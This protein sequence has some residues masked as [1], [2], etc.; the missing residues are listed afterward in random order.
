MLKLS[1]PIDQIARISPPYK[2]RLGRLKIQTL[3]DLLYHI[4]S[5]YHDFS[6]VVPIEKLE[7]GEIATVQGTV[8][9]I[10]NTRTWKKRMVLTEAIVEDD[11]GTV[12]AIWFNQPY[13]VRN[14]GKG[15]RISL[16]GKLE[17]AYENTFLSNPAY[18]II[19]GQVT[20]NE[21]REGLTHT[22]GLIAVYPETAGVSSRWLRYIIKTLL[23]KIEL[24]DFLPPEIK[25]AHDLRG[26]AAALE[27][28]H[29]P[30]VREDHKKA[31][32][33]LS[34]EELFLLSLYVLRERM[35]IKRERARVIPL[36]IPL[37][38]RFVRSLPF[39]LTNA[40]RLAL[41]EILRDTA[42]PEPMNR[43]LE[44]DVGS[45]KTIV[46]TAAALH[47]AAA[48]YQSAFMA[49][50]EI[51]A[52]QHFNEISKTLAKENVT[53]GLL[54][55]GSAKIAFGGVATTKQKRKD[56][57]EGVASGE[58]DILIGTHALIEDRV[59][60]K[61][62]AS[63]VVDEQHRFGIRQRMALARGNPQNQRRTS[64]KL[65]RNSAS[66]LQESAQQMRI[67]HLLSMTATPIPRTLALTIY[68]DL[69]ISL[70]NEMP[71]GRQKI[72]TR[73]VPPAKRSDAYQFIAKEI[74]KGRQIFIICPLIDESEKLEDVAAA[75]KEHERL[76]RNVFSRFRLELLHGKIK[77]KEKERIMRAFKEGKTDVLVSTSVV[78]VGIDIPNA[79]VMLIEGADRFGLAQLHQFRGRVGRGMHQS[80]CLL[81]T[82]STSKS[83]HARLRALVEA[84][85]GFELAEHDLKIRGPGEFYGTRQSGL[86]DIAMKSLGDITLVKQTREAAANLLKKDPDLAS[87]PLL[88][89]KL[90]DFRKTIHLE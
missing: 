38:K 80:Y 58:I 29:F 40:Q 21:Q 8:A 30:K 51:L 55:G 49:P 44:G 54:T 18:E 14:I 43:L 56:V 63:V 84:K 65:L 48:G 62:L 72:I 71:K 28:V 85:N 83:T 1:T 82:D 50:T 36:A 69:D 89:E 81:F 39:P 77:P 11:T 2:K 68:G 6:H 12:K 57:L 31:R 20:R 61:Q 3:K 74:E 87:Y 86:P 59:R 42:K 53:L 45:G 13:L 37:I 47:V 64:Q 24:K 26:L 23:P 90:Q 17:F 19:R 70:L 4:P 52:E 66:S 5:R 79:T 16:S 32:R 25:N 7:L 78:E 67:P 33:R 9:D 27:D 76:S 10:Q 15:S 22:A 34:F 75:T 46:A 88:R 35:N 41:W 73:V 60:F